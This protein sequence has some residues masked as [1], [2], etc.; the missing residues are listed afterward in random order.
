MTESFTI[1]SSRSRRPVRKLLDTPSY[2][3]YL[4]AE[5]VQDND[6]HAM[7]MWIQHVV[8][9]ITSFVSWLTVDTTKDEN[10]M[11]VHKDIKAFFAHYCIGISSLTF[12]K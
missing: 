4:L 3:S 12:Q 8:T 9:Y 1:C 2:F 5:I 11:P 10:Y 7:S 6:T